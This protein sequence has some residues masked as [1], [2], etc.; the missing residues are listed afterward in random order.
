MNVVLI[1]NVISWVATKKCDDFNKIILFFSSDLFQCLGVEK[2]KKGDSETP[3][4]SFAHIMAGGIWAH[5]QSEEIQTFT[6]P[7]KIT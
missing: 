2:P 7:A 6:R 1:K 3:K 4:F 5:F